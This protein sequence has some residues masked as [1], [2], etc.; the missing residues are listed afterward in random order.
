MVKEGEFVRAENGIYCFRENDVKPY[1][2]EYSDLAAD[3][4]ALVQKQYPLLDFTIMELIQLHDFVN[5][6][7]AHNTLFLSVEADLIDFVFDT[8]KEQY[9]SKVLINPTSEIYYQ[10]W[11]DNMI[12]INKLITEAPKGSGVPWH[13]RLEKLLVD[14]AA[15]PLF[16]DSISESEYPGLMKMHSPCMW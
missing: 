12:V 9:F 4:A 8:L 10:Y 15:D 1:E 7:I 14:I 11:S 3:V 5:H 13:T 6:Q 2:H 16:M